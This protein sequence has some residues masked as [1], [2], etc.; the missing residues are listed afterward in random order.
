MNKIDFKKYKRFFA[1]G[2]SFTDY[3]WP[4]WANIISQEIPNSTVFGKS[5]AG[6][7]FIYQSLIEANI[8]YKLNKDDLIMV[9]FSNVTREDRFMRSRGTWV[10]PG[11]LFHQSEY[12]ENFMKNL[13]CHHGYLMR[14]LNLVYGCKNILNSIGCEYELMSIVPFNSLKSDGDMMDDIDYLLNFHKDTISQI[15]PSVLEVLFNNDWNTRLPR[16][17]YKVN[18]TDDLFVDNHPTTLEH[19]EYLQLIFPETEFSQHTI[20]YVKKYNQLIFDKDFSDDTS[21]HDKKLSSRL[22]VTYYE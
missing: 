15:K 5:G 3:H 2:C 9:M 20:E 14:D 12:D 21:K 11:N 13:F 8:R 17:K 10:T 22:G 1:F 7:F 6:N 16:P 19:F 18:W 4:T